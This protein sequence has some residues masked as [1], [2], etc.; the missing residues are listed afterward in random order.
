MTRNDWL[1]KRS[2]IAWAALTCSLVASARYFWTFS[3]LK[4]TPFYID[5][6]LTS[7]VSLCFSIVGFLFLFDLGNRELG[8]ISILRESSERESSENDVDFDRMTDEFSWYLVMAPL[9]IFSLAPFLKFKIDSQLAMGFYFLLGPFWALLFWGAQRHTGLTR[10]L[11]RLLLAVI[12]G[13][14]L[15]QA[16]AAR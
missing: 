1:E 10:N 5:S 2:R 3:L 4:N 15:R 6:L 9:F 8:Y 11:F 12:V 16:F 14:C 13:F 7:L